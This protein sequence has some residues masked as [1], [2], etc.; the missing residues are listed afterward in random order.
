MKGLLATKGT[1]LSASYFAN[2]SP[3]IQIRTITSPKRSIPMPIRSSAAALRNSACHRLSLDV[4]H[5]CFVISSVVVV[6]LNLLWLP[7]HEAT[8]DTHGHC[9]Y[10]LDIL[11][12]RYGSSSRLLRP[13]HTLGARVLLG[14]FVRRI[15]RSCQ[16]VRRAPPHPA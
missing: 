15:G 13:F 12:Y 2:L 4:Q 5:C 8:C 1:M 16:R 7:N 10:P 9:K 14:H 6:I 3:P 11:K